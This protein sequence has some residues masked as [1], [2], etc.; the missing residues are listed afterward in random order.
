MVFEHCFKAEQNKTPI[1]ICF[2][3][4][5]SNNICFQQNPN[6]YKTDKSNSHSE[7]GVLWRRKWGVHFN[8]LTP[9]TELWL[10][11]DS[12][13][14]VRKHWIEGTLESLLSQNSINRGS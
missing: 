5:Y 2:Q 11:R 10:L 3:Q 7:L 12:R 9:T 6:K 14:T 13:N 4:I 8:L 1:N